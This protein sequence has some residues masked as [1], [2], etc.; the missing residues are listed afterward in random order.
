VNDV[1]R[2]KVHGPVKTLRTEFAVWD[3]DREEWQPPRHSSLTSFLPGGRVSACDTNNADGSVAHSRWLYDESDRLLESTSWLNDGPVQRTAYFYD[4]AGRHRRTMRNETDIETCTYD[5]RGI[6][7][8][9]CLLVFRADAYGIEGTDQSYGAPGAVKMIITYD[10]K[11]LPAEVVFE[12]AN[13][14]RVTDVN[15]MRD[16]AGRLLREEM[17]FAADSLLTLLRKVA[18]SWLLSWRKPLG[19]FS[20]ASPTPT[21]REDGVLN[22]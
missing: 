5:T 14:R 10:E 18:K 22:G 1:S 12:D 6:K 17:R 16:S 11:D 4:E 21:I 2:W 13:G 7:T 15:F 20:H 9:Q 3:L 8:K 19:N